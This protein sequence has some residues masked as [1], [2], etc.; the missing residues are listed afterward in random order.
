MMAFIIGAFAFGI[1]SIIYVVFPLSSYVKAFEI[2]KH[3]Y[4]TR[5]IRKNIKMKLKITDKP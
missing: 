1:C 5:K 2:L 4:T 3:M